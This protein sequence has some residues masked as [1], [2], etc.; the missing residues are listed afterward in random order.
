MV[1]G[2]EVCSVWS[3][4]HVNEGSFH[5]CLK[6]GGKRYEKEPG[7]QL[8]LSP[9]Y[10]ARLPLK[11]VLR[12]EGREVLM[13]KALTGPTGSFSHSTLQVSQTFSHS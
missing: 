3:G 8:D 7:N 1:P 4:G 11:G 13:A 10:T 5:S 9:V 12:G 6:R 2:K